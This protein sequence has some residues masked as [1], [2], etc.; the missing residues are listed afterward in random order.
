MGV[1]F[2][3]MYVLVFVVTKMVLVGRRVCVCLWPSSWQSLAAGKTVIRLRRS[4]EAAASEGAANKADGRGRREGLTDGP[5]G[6]G[7]GSGSA[8]AAAT[9]AFAVVGFGAVSSE[10]ENCFVISR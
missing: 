4:C 6:G 7:G 5:V 3:Y 9:A 1:F 8:I 10:E 2:A